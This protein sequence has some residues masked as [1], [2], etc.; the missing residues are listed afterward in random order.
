VATY[1]LSRSA[2]DDK[3]TNRDSGKVFSD[4]S[5]RGERLQCPAAGDETRWAGEKGGGGMMN[6]AAQYL[7]RMTVPAEVEWESGGRTERRLH[8]I[9]AIKTIG[10]VQGRG[11]GSK[12][13]AEEGR[14]HEGT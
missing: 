4:S 9:A 7:E 14:V 8:L 10:G 12:E 6:G 1:H 11:D 5:R 13:R 2:P 3:R